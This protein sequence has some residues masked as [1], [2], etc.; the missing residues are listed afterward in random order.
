MLL[1]V[2]GVSKYVIM[3]NF[4]LIKIIINIF[5]NL[6]CRKNILLLFVISFYCPCWLLS[7]C[8]CLIG[9]I[10][11]FAL[12]AVVISYMQNKEVSKRA[13]AFK[14]CSTR[15]FRIYT[16]LLNLY[17]TQYQMKGNK[18][19]N[20]KSIFKSSSKV[21]CL[22]VAGVCECEPTLTEHLQ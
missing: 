20:P 10:S 12:T 17:L 11:V 14:N 19:N 7:S 18:K 21:H 2:I 6:W 9:N 4:I 5:C 8:H 15:D 22:K 1:H 16:N 13:V 3:L